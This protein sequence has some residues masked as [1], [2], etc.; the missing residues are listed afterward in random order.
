MEIKKH[1]AYFSGAIV[2]GI[3]LGR[4]TFDRWGG[5]HGAACALGSGLRAI[6]LS[7]TA[8]SAT[9][10]FHSLGTKAAKRTHKIE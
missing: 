8:Q 10:V 7:A 1:Y 9:R 6:G 5:S 4:Q 3:P 2:A